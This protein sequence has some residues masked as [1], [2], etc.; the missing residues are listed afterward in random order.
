MNSIQV[1]KNRQYCAGVP[2]DLK[3]EITK[4][5]M[6]IM[7]LCL[8]LPWYL[9]SGCQIA[10]VRP[11]FQKGSRG[12]VRSSRP[13]SLKSALGKLVENGMKNQI[14]WH[15]NK[16]DLLRNS[17]HDVCDFYILVFFGEINKHI[18]RKIQL[19]YPT[20]ISKGFQKICPWIPHCKLLR[21]STCYAMRGKVI[22][23]QK[24]S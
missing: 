19:V 18:N 22:A 1:P 8:K 21:E 14:H 5:L 12:D 2:K 24:Y 23:W 3:D 13:V 11:T 7:T 20:W 15:F 6:Q 16:F 4:W 10:N 17:Q 9:K